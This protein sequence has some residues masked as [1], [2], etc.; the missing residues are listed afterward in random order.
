ME[1]HRPDEMEMRVLTI[2]AV[3]MIAMAIAYLAATGGFVDLFQIRSV[4]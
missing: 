1:N 3:I 2:T 4:P